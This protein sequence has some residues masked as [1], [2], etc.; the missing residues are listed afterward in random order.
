MWSIKHKTLQS[1]TPHYYNTFYTS[2][3]R[4]NVLQSSSHG[5]SWGGGLGCRQGWSLGRLVLLG[6]ARFWKRVIRGRWCVCCCCTSTCNTQLH[7]SSCRKL[8]QQALGSTW[9]RITLTS[10]VWQ[11]SK[12]WSLHGP[13]RLSSLSHVLVVSS[14]PTALSEQQHGR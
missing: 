13:P 14:S 4:S 12:K 3:D 7:V 6:G 2:T 1:S 10:A 8:S 9:G 11:V 5:Y